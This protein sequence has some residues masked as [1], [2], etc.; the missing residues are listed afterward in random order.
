MPH[1]QQQIIDSLPSHLQPFVAIQDYQQYTARDHAVW[2]FLLYQLK[3]NLSKSAHPTYLEGLKKTGISLEAIPKI[4]DINSHL[5]KIGWRAVVV[6][7]FLPPAIFMEFQA[8]KVL[9]IA[10]NMRSFEHMLYT[11]APDI[12]HESA[13]HA[14]FIIDIDYGEFLQE[15]GRLG[16]QAISSSSDLD[17][18]NAIRTLSI[19]KE[20]AD[21]SAEDIEAAEQNLTNAI[22]AN[23]TSSEA[24]L[25]ARLHWWTVEYGLV[26]SLKDYRIYGAGLLSSLG[27]STHCLDDNKV[28]KVML[29][30]DSI[31][32]DYDITT[33]Q[34]QLFVTESCR[35]LSQVLAEYGDHMCCNRGGTSA[36][37]EAIE[38]STVNTYKLNSGIQVSGVIAKNTKNAVGETIY[39]N[40][41]GPTQLSHNNKQLEGHGTEYHAEGF[42]SPVGGLIAMERCLSQYHVDELKHYGIETGKNVTLRYLSGV[43]VRG[44]LVTIWREQQQNILFS[45]ENCTVTDVDNNVLFDPDWG[46]YD[47]AIGTSIES[48]VGGSADKDKF[49]IYQAP[50]TTATEV[51]QYDQATQQQFKWYQALRNLRESKPT[52]EPISELIQEIESLESPDWL[53]LY[54]SLE[55]AIEY[56]LDQQTIEKLKTNLLEIKSN[57]KQDV[58]TLIDYGLARHFN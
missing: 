10:V 28:K 12:V 37:D 41:S 47:M 38:A 51:Q 11:P 20:T 23:Q 2:R 52:T 26:G 42:G 3:Q 15:F 5:E 7:G 25:L 49:P 39:I 8:I 34:P 50:S 21:A 33:Q 46:M 4:E 19:V 40:T 18:Y 56:K 17:V 44:D 54:E 9:V 57:S 16:M 55:L 14:P 22:K 48:V 29:T 30:V 32:T 45:F 6:D 36:I 58:V 24:A 35:H 27:E 1:S 43:T 31:K 53:L 13:G